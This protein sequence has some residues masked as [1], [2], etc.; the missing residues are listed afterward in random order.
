MNVSASF[1]LQP[2]AP[3]RLDLT[4]W[5]LRRRSRNQIDRWDGTYQRALLVDG[6]AV[7]VR[8]GQS[9]SVWHPRLDVE[10]G[11]AS[12]HTN[13]EIAEA[14]FQLTR[15]LGIDVDL[16]TFYDRAD[17][18]PSSRQLKD[19]LLGLRPPRFPTVFESLVNAV[20]NQQLSLEVG[21]TLLN[22][23]TA[24]LGQPVPG[25]G[26]LKAFPTPEAVLA[27]SRDDLRH[28]WDT[29]IARSNPCGAS[30]MRPVPDCSMRRSSSRPTR[31]RRPAG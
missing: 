22:R 20:A 9:G 4:V 21:L 3:Y 6:R 27:A 8:V 25:C 26:N 7:A 13:A 10:L 23:L 19:R 16:T 11:G 24:S 5:A 17:A 31:P 30:P 12:Q 29:V 15:L 2:G 28:S 1:A 14:R 18:Q